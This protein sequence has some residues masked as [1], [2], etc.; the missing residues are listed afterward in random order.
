MTVEEAVY[1]RLSGGSAVQAIVG[2]K[3]YPLVAPQSA[4][5]P[6]LIY[7][8]SSHNRMRRLNGSTVMREFRMRIDG[9]ATSYTTAKSLRDAVLGRLVNYNG[10]ISNV[11]I[12]D[13]DQEDTSDEH[14]P[15][16]HA[17]E[18]GIFGAGIDLVVYYTG[19][20]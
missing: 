17:D 7:Q 18:K 3:I 1:S 11:V 20:D 10:T 13:I 2:S 15:P 9:Y 8:E 16:I 12:E 19:G 14:L 5:L 4:S 6:F